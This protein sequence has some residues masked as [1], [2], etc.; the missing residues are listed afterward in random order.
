MNPILKMALRHARPGTGSTNT[1]LN[2]R[3]ALLPLPIPNLN[4]ILKE[5][6]WVLAGGLATRAYMPERVTQNVMIFIH[7]DDESRARAAFRA[8]GYILTETLAFANP[9]LSGFGVE[10][11]NEPGNE[12]TKYR[13]AIMFACEK[14]LRFCHF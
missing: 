6:P 1:F 7:A 9:S 14:P 4:A 13:N 12:T 8:A 10:R 5:I 11:G 3:T 2:R